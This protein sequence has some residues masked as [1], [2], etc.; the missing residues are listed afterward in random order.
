MPKFIPKIYPT[1][2]MTDS[3]LKPDQWLIEFWTSHQV[4]VSTQLIFDNWILVCSPKDLATLSRLACKP[5]G[6][7]PVLILLFTGAGGAPVLDT[8]GSKMSPMAGVLSTVLCWPPKTAAKSSWTWV[9][10]GF[11]EVLLLKPVENE[12]ILKWVINKNCWSS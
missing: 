12:P 10:N 2:L 11:V 6:C 3:S 4:T 9:S 5:P 1:Q 8:V 7:S